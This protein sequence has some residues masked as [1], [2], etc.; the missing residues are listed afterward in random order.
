MTLSGLTP[1][2]FVA[3]ADAARAIAFYR[4]VLGLSLISDDAF[5]ATFDMAGVTLRVQKV[6]AVTPAPYTTLGWTTADIAPLVQ[7][8]AAAGI[9]F[10]RYPWMTQSPEGIWDAPDGGRVAW[11]K[12]P[13]G[14]LLSVSQE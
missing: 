3:T 9:V 6:E 2:T 7:R 8:L 4:D 10:E 12:D 5:A 14:N 11:F 13:D 1:M